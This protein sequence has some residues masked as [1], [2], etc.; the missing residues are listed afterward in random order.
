MFGNAI[1]QNKTQGHG[2]N[3]MTV[4]EAKE[5]R[6]F[7]IHTNHSYRD[8]DLDLKVDVNEENYYDWVMES[9]NETTTPRGVGP[10]VFVEK[11]E[12]ELD[13]DDFDEDGN[14]TGNEHI[15]ACFEDG[16]IFNPKY[17]EKDHNGNLYGEYWVIS[18]WGTGGN[19]YG[20]GKHNWNDVFLTEEE[21]DNELFSRVEKYDFGSD[22][23]RST[24]YWSDI[25]DA[26]EEALNTYCEWWGVSP[27]TA[28]SILTKRE[29]LDQS[30][31]EK[32]EDTLYTAGV[33]KIIE[34][35]D[36]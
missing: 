33:A 14:Y 31:T 20:S 23:Q 11:E 21:A 24:R 27:Q 7:V 13:A 2:R 19:N 26:E 15:P 1:R 28:R 10:R 8:P 22:D 6:I 35:T 18:T 30:R 29:K 36:H 9:V 32:N 12:I 4:Q 17:L 25:E 5:T 16:G 3:I 34:S